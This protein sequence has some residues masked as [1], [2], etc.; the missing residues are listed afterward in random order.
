MYK[1]AQ[2][3]RL[4]AQRNEALVL[5]QLQ[6][7]R[8]EIMTEYHRM[9]GFLQINDNLIQDIPKEQETLYIKYRSLDKEPERQEYDACKKERDLILDEKNINDRLYFELTGNHL[10]HHNELN[11]SESS[12]S[13]DVSLLLPESQRSESSSSQQPITE[14]PLPITEPPIRLPGVPHRESPLQIRE[15][16]ILLDE[17]NEG[18]LVQLQQP[19]PKPS[20][21]P[22]AKP[23]AQT[24]SE[25]ARALGL[26]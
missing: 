21:K 24:A 12:S 11:S 8:V 16:A 6:S 18:A 25:L 22:S 5:S 26:D 3:R 2:M 7:K 15:P 20:A 23:P 13:Y 14:S 17:P 19:V 10:P 1:I 4:D 9:K